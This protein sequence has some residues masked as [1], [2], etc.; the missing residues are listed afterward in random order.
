VSAEAKPEAIVRTMNIYYPDPDQDRSN[1]CG[2]TSDFEVFF[3]RLIDAGNYMC[4]TAAIAGFL[5][6][7]SIT[8]MNCDEIDASHTI[9]PDCLDPSGSNFRDPLEVIKYVD[10]VATQWPN[11]NNSSMIQSDRTHPGAIG[12]QYIAD[13]HHALGYEDV[14][15]GGFC[16]DAV[17][18]AGE[19]PA[20]CPADCPDVCG[21]GLCT[22]SEDTTTCPNDCGTLCGAGVCHGAVG[23]GSGA[24]CAPAAP[25]QTT[26]GRRAV[27][28]RHARGS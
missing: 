2:S 5:C 17:C 26:N 27:G 14:P 23:S 11:A 8:A 4:T 16:G 20:T 19:D 9:D 3:P 12:Q 22:G 24:C 18:D 10:G 1:F 13:A 28:P 7:D 21:D 25:A 15:G 6:A